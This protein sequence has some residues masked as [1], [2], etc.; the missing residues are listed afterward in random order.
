MDAIMVIVAI[1]IGA[2]LW[3]LYHK[4][5]HVIYFGGT[6]YQVISELVTCL[7][8]GY[9]ITLLGA[10][11]FGWF[12][13]FLI[14]VAVVIIKIIGYALL[15]AVII[16]C[17]WVIYKIIKAIV[18]HIKKKR[19]TYVEKT[20][21]NAEISPDEARASDNA[22]SNTADDETVAEEKSSNEDA[23]ENTEE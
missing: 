20:E 4:I 7:F 22:E 19:G 21:E 11:L 6:F 8:L 15:V 10:K 2:I 5:F 14:N 9:G 12:F 17:I 13:V 3:V 18:I 1:I 23:D 16:F